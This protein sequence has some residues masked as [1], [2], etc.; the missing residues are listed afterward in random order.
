MADDYDKTASYSLENI[1]NND[2]EWNGYPVAYP[3]GAIVCE[4]VSERKGDAGI[5]ELI[6]GP[7]RNHREIVNLVSGILNVSEQEFEKIWNG[8]MRGYQ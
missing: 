3:A 4:I 6:N 5:I 1:L 8:K 7:S 2:V